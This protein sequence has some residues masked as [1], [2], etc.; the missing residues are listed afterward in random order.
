MLPNLWRAA[1]RAARA[2]AR[3]VVLAGAAAVASA[4]GAAAH[5]EIYFQVGAERVQ[6]GAEVEVRGDLDAGEAFEITLV[7]KT[8]GAR[9]VIATVPAFE[10]GHFQTYV[11]IPADTSTGEYLVEAAYDLT[12]VRAQLTVAGPAIVAGQDQNVGEP[13]HEG[14]GAPSASGSGSGAGEFAAAPSAGLAATAASDAGAAPVRGR[15]DALEGLG[16][17][18]IAGVL[19]VALVGGLRV[20]RKSG[21]PGA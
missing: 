6:P 19:A 15:R 7:S 12:V 5:G 8:D 21:R 13:E 17:V 11:V 18:A 3:P 2:L 20:L 1:L 9:R 16:I 10:E 4:G 14:F